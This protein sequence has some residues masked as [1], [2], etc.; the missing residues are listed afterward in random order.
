MRFK[1]TTIPKPWGRELIW[2]HAPKKY[3]GKI[4]VIEKGKRLSLQYHRRKHESLFVLRGK[5]TLRLG[6]KTY[7]AGPGSAFA[8][9]TGTVHRF[10]SRHGRVT[11]VEVSTT[12]LDDVVRLQDDYGRSG[13]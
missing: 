9:P 13:R 3:A 10:E 8:V 4:L 11:L 12:E 1:T 7:V 6:K 2:A 5:L